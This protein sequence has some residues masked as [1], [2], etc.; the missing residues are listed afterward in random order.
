MKL[1][2]L[3]GKIEIT[4]FA[5]INL[6]NAYIK[7]QD[8]ATAANSLTIKIGDGNLTYSEKKTM[9]YELDR[10]VLDDVREGDDV[11]IDV[12]FDVV[13]EYITGSGG[14]GAAGT[15]EDFL[16]QV[17]AY[18]GNTSSDPDACRPYAVDVII[19]YQPEPFSCGDKET[20]TL[21]D[22][23]YESLDHDLSNAS[24]SCTGRCN[25]TKATTVRA[26]Q[27]ST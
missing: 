12:S 7:L 17:G 13:W 23:R 16:K 15:A 9:E 14:T 4:M 24:I 19:E 11:P 21:A 27:S 25:I 18:S 5:R 1:T 8:G 10:G 2:G 20:I 22:F 26:A 3:L 6:K